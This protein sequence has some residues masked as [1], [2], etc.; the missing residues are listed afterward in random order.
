M[1]DWWKSSINNPLRKF[2]L[3]FLHDVFLFRLILN[4]YDNCWSEQ[5]FIFYLFLL[6]WTVNNL[7]GCTSRW[8]AVGPFFF[9]DAKN[10]VAMFQPNPFKLCGKHFALYSLTILSENRLEAVSTT[11]D[12]Y[13]G[14]LV[15]FDAKTVIVW[16]L[17]N[18]PRA[19]ISFG[20]IYNKKDRE[21]YLLNNKMSWLSQ[22][23]N[24]PIHITSDYIDV[25]IIKLVFTF[26]KTDTTRTVN[27]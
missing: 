22:T 26:C 1:G 15:F 24:K 27:S 8:L 17:L 11:G 14:I 3:F 23:K 13:P 5:N 12:W 6:A 16:S 10:A 20:A 4:P 18:R 21:K 7:K 25:K 2:A 19:A 9:T